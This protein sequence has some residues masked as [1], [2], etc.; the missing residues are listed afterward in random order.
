VEDSLDR[1][2][3]ALAGRQ[4][5]VFTLAHADALGFTRAQ[6]DRRIRSGRWAVPY[7]RVYRIAGAPLS[8][9]GRLLASCWVAH[10]LAV[11]SHRSAARLRD[12]PGG[13]T[14]LVEITCKRWKRAKADGLIVH[15]T[16]LLDV[17]DI[18]IV[19]GIPC[20]S[21]EQTLLGLAAVVADTVVE[22][23]VDRA[24]HKQMTTIRALEA[25]VQ[26]KGKRGR[27]GVGVLRG[28]VRGLD[29]LA[30]VPESAMETKLK[31]LLRRHGFPTP[32]FQ[33]EVWHDGR[34]VARVDAAYPEHRIA[35]E[36]DSYEHHTGKQAIVRDNDRR[37]ALRKATWRTVVF[38]AQDVAQDGGRALEALRT[39]LSFGAPDASL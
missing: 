27:N 28:V 29:P 35:I 16:K 8:W 2:V 37:N 24:L 1:R 13:R 23:A 12:L 7:E 20:A 33:Y 10:G 11:A 6:R 18:D 32:V 31:Q 38:T 19:D 9:E 22:M 39:E 4:H 5:G 3:A 17:A 14:D 34:F 15:E 25:F 36:Y 30:G 26:H 21:V